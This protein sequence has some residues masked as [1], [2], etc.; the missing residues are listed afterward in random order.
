MKI[1]KTL[2]FDYQATTPV[3]RKVLEE[4]LPF[5]CENFGNPSSSDHFIGWEANKAFNKARSSI[6]ENLGIDSD[7]IIFTSGA[8]EANNM[9]ISSFCESESIKTILYSP[10]DHKSTIEPIK[11]C[12]PKRVVQKISINHDGLVNLNELEARAKEGPCLI[13]LCIVNNEIGTIQPFKEIFQ[14]AQKTRSIVHFDAAQ[15]PCVLDLS[16]IIVNAD[17]VTFSGHKVYGPKGVGCMIFQREIKPHLRP[18][19]RGGGQQEHLRSGTIPVPLCI[20]FAKALEIFKQ[21]PYERDKIRELRNLFFQKLKKA[22]PFIELNGPPLDQRHPGNLNI[23]FCGYDARELLAVMQPLLA[24]SMGSACNSGIPEPSYVL[25]ET[26]LTREEAQ[27]SIRFSL[28]RYSKITHIEEAI[29]IIKESLDT[30][31][32]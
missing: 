27:S 15:A 25:R 6:G 9:V 3:D 8:S 2:Y 19:I 10:I 20:G 30:L 12:L 24:A 4:M 21:S 17:I 22:F 26:G 7:Q 31:S 16:Q 23:R 28:G 5:F 13:S 14:I 29:L 18:L 1:G 32:Y 11:S